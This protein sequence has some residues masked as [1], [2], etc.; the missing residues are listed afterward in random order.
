MIYGDGGPNGLH[1]IWRAGIPNTATTVLYD[2]DKTVGLELHARY[3]SHRAAIG[4]QVSIV[5]TV[6]NTGTT[7]PSGF[8]IEIT[9]VQRDDGNE[10]MDG[11]AESRVGCT[12]AGEIKPRE[13]VSCTATFTVGQADFDST[14]LELDATATDGTATSKPFRIYIKILDG[15]VVGFKT[16]NLVVTEGE[17]STADLVVIREG[18]IKEEVQVAYITRP[19][20]GNWDSDTATEGEDYADRS[21]PPGVIT[22]KINETT[23]TTSFD[24]IADELWEKRER[25]EVILQPPD[26]V[27][28]PAASS[29]RMVL[30][31]DN[32]AGD[33]NYRPR[34]TLHLTEDGTVTEDSGSVEFAVRLN[35]ASVEPLRY[36]VSLDSDAGTAAPGVDFVDPGTITVALAPGQKEATFTVALIDDDEAEDPETFRLSIT[37]YSLIN[38]WPPLGTTREATVTIVDDDRVEPSEVRLTLT[39]NGRTFERVNERA[40]RRD[41]TV[42]ASFHADTPVGTSR[43]VDP[44][45]EDTTVRVQFDPGSTA[46]L[47]DFQAFDDLEVVIPA[48]QASGTSTLRFKPEQDR[49]DE[50]D[51]TVTLGGSVVATSSVENSLPVV[52]SS[53]TIADDDTRGI[54]VVPALLL[55]MQ[56]QLVENGDSKTYTVVLDSQPTDTVTIEIQFD[57]S[58]QLNISPTTLTFT[59]NDWNTPQTVT[60]WAEDDGIINVENE[61]SFEHEVSGGDYDQVELGGVQVSIEDTTVPYIYVGNARAL[62]SSGHVEFTV[63]VRPRLPTTPINVRYS[64]ADGTATAGSDYT[65]EVDSGQTDRNLSIP[66]NGSIATIR[67]PISNDT[68]DEADVETFTFTLRLA[69]STKAKLAGDVSVLTATGSIVDDDPAPVVTIS[70]PDGS[71]SHISE[72][73]KTPVTFTL[74]LSGGSSEDATVDYATGLA[75]G[76]SGIRTVLSRAKEGEDYTAATG[77]VTFR[78]GEKIKTITVELKNDEISESIEYFGL[79]L[80]SPRNAEFNNRQSEEGAS[81]GILD[82]DPRDVVISPSRIMLEEPRQGATATADSYTVVLKSQ[83]TATTTVAI[84]GATD[85]AVDL[86]RTSRTFTP[87]DWDTPQ[88]VTI[89]PVRD[90]DAVSE[91]ITVTHTLTGGDYGGLRAG[92]VLVRV[93]DSDTRDVIVSV[94]RL[95]ISEGHD[96][97]Y[98]VK[99]ASQPTATTTVSVIVAGAAQLTTNPTELTFTTSNWNTPKTI[100][101]TA[102]QDDDTFNNTAT[103]TNVASGSDYVSVTRTVRVTVTDGD[104]PDVRI[105][106]VRMSL[107]EGS[108]DYYMVSLLTKPTGPVTI[109]IN[110]VGDVETNKTSLSFDQANWHRPQSVR[111]SAPE[112][113]DGFGGTATVTHTASGGDYGSVRIPSVNVDMTD[114]DP[115]GVTVSTTTLAITEGSSGTYTINLDTQ[116]TATTTLTVNAEGEGDLTAVG[117]NS[118]ST[119]TFTT[120]NWSAPQTVT[121][122]A[123]HD[124]DLADHMAILDHEISGGDYNSGGEG[125]PDSVNVPSVNVTVVDDDTPELVLSTSTLPVVEGDP[126]G[127]S[128]TV[129]LSHEPAETVT[130]EITGHSG[131]DLGLSKTTLSFATSTWNIAQTVTVTAD[132]DSNAVDEEEM[133]THTASGGEYGGVAADLAVTVTDDAPESVTV[134]FESDTHTVMEGSSAMLRVTLSADPEREVVIPITRTEQGG[135]TSTDYSGVPDVLTFNPRETSKTIVFT[136]EQ[137]TVDDDDE[138]VRLTFGDLPDRVTEGSV[139]TTT[140]SITD[141]DDPEVTVGFAQVSYTV[142]EGA[143]TSI[144]IILSADPERSVDMDIMGTGQGGATSTDFTIAPDR[145]TFNPGETSKTIVFTAEQDAVDD[146][147][148]SVRLTFGTLPD[149]VSNGATTET[150][151]SIDDDDDPMVRVSFE[152]DSYSVS[153]G[154]TTTVSVVLSADPERSVDID[155]VKTNRG[156]A[157]DSDYSGVPQSLIFDRGVAERSFVVTAARDLISDGRESVELTFGVQLPT[158]VEL[159]ATST[160]SVRIIDVSSQ[161]GTPP[162]QVSFGHSG[163][164]RSRGRDGDR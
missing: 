141:D 136:A 7:T 30:I 105:T 82:D 47:T 77:T 66:A 4:D 119:L 131:T 25:F 86:D 56:L 145:V 126:V 19:F 99:L 61:D 90:A 142:D 32:R 135:A 156:G 12:I 8:P 120:S 89:T 157:T 94:S 103:V 64:T 108:Y 39:F 38:N 106:P 109:S 31:R 55:S 152:S 5:F 115:R 149:R 43:T 58:G 1:R 147:D 20:E 68:V 53:F 97:T 146:D 140:V 23:A 85:P 13:S 52:P 114:D 138:S 162:L 6:I 24:I 44:L 102:T 88:T 57:E 51:E 74:T 84:G 40:S 121:V 11:Q 111:V 123:G 129:S 159:G 154:S 37:H 60:V 21:V 93:D 95:T 10:S 41:I 137:D 130:V 98:T 143:T 158:G 83:P 150:T 100:T 133:L 42:T 139:S 144:E 75:R 29:T 87:I 50:D 80:H 153:E 127:A 132:D 155:L 2:D 164:P 151:I 128:Y 3:R 22:F 125:S 110:P 14:P 62:E 104:R 28:M 163:V 79:N 72:D 33:V 35:Y 124:N 49:I 27:K 107:V 15:I 73:V 54:T 69:S 161:G 122:T 46:D 91:F 65:R 34:A 48:G 9:S 117:P 116:P 160:S 18:F 78:P 148:E 63:R 134:S 76:L 26:G 81:V 71:L 96:D 70:G 101:V 59:S 17:D 36:L 92:S 67:I 118:T 113:D 112:D 45:D 16:A